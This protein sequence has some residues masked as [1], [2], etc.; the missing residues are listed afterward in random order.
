MAP[1]GFNLQFSGDG[2]GQHWSGTWYEQVRC[3]GWEHWL[4][5]FP[6]LPLFFMILLP[7]CPTSLP[8]NFPHLF[9]LQLSPLLTHPLCIGGLQAASVPASSEALRGARQ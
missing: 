4:F 7:T 2:S 6:V 8:F 9:A 5:P 3:M 1:C